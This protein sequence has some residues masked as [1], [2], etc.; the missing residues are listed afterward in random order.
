MLPVMRGVT[1]LIIGSNVKVKLAKFE[2]VAAGGGGGGLSLVG[3]VSLFQFL[4]Q[5][6]SVFYTK[7]FCLSCA[8]QHVDQFPS[9]IRQVYLL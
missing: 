6:C 3:Q 7:R 2:F 4:F 1:L 8:D 9:E 5:T